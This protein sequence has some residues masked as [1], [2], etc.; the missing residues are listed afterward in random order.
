MMNHLRNL[1]FAVL[2]AAGLGTIA[3]LLI[4]NPYTHQAVALAI[5]S[6]AKKFTYVEVKFQAIKVSLLPLGID[7]FGLELVHSEK[8]EQPVI[9]SS[10][11]RA[12]ISLWALLLGRLRLSIIESRDL[13]FTW[14]L[15]AMPEHHAN[16]HLYGGFYGLLRDPPPLSAEEDHL[17][18]PLPFA[19]PIDRVML[20]SAKI[21]IDHNFSP[22][23]KDN[24][25]L[26]SANFSGLDLD[27][28]PGEF[29]NIA[30]KLHVGVAN[31]AIGAQSLIEDGELSL[32]GNITQ[33]AVHSTTF[34]IRSERANLAGSLTGLIQSTSNKP[35]LLESIDLDIKSKGTANLS[36]LGSILDIGDT[37]GLVTGEMGGRIFIPVESKRPLAIEVKGPAAVEDGYI[38]GIRLHNSRGDLRITEDRLAFDRVEAV[39]GKH[40]VGEAKGE[41]LFNDAIDFNFQI[42]PESLRLTEI[43]NVFNVDFDGVDFKMR[44]PLVNLKGKGFPFALTVDGALEL[45]ELNVALLNATPPKPSA[46]PSCFV[47]TQLRANIQSFFID[48]LEG[49]CL[50]K[51]S[52]TE[53]SSSTSPYEM[54]KPR[55]EKEASPLNV[56]GPIAFSEKQGINLKILS[57]GFHADLLNSM[58]PIELEGQGPITVVVHGPYNAVRADISASVNNLRAH[59]MPFGTV[60]GTATAFDD[61]VEWQNVTSTLPNQG[62]LWS[63]KGKLDFKNTFPVD[64]DFHA[65]NVSPTIVGEHIRSLFP[66]STVAFG[67]SRFDGQIRGR[68]LEPLTYIGEFQTALT[69]LSY[70]NETFADQLQIKGNASRDAVDISNIVARLGSLS[71]NASLKVDKSDEAVAAGK[72]GLWQELG[73]NLKDQVEINFQTGPVAT[74]TSPSESD[75]LKR[76][77]YIGSAL[78]TAGIGGQLTTKGSLKGPASQLVGTVEGSVAP[79]SILSTELAPVKFRT[80]VVGQKIDVVANH[81]GSSLE[82]RISMRLFEPGVPFEWYMR[83]NRLDLRAFGTPVF[84]KDPRNYAYFSGDWDLK[85]KISDFWRAEGKIQLSDLR[86]QFMRDVGGQ[87]KTAVLRNEKNA[88]VKIHDGFW[89]FAD[90]SPWTIGGDSLK[91]AVTLNGNRLPDNLNIEF[92][93]IVDMNLIREFVEQ[94]ESGTGKIKVNG[95]IKGTTSEPK[96]QLVLSDVEKSNT[97][98]WEPLS[99]GLADARPAFRNIR[100]KVIYENGHFTIDRLYAD[101]GNGHVTLNGT[102]Q[103][104]TE[105][106]E[107][108]RMEVSLR[109]AAFALPLSVFLFDSTVTGDLILSGTARPYKLSGQVQVTRARSGRDFDIRQEILNAALRSKSASSSNL[110]EPFMDL[111]VAVSARSSI[112]VT[113]R[114]LQGVLSADL[115]VT[116]NDTNPS[117]SG[118]VEVVRG[119]FFYRRDFTI[120]KGVFVFDDPLKPDPYLDVFAASEVGNYRVYITASGRASDPRIDLSVDPAVR[121]DGTP[122]S[123]VD[124]LLLLS[125]GSFPPTNRNGQ[126]GFSTEDASKSAGT[127]AL[128]L[129]VGQFEEPVEKLFDLSGQRIVRQVYIDTYLSDVSNKPMPR[130]NVP[131]NLSRDLDV[132]LRYDAE[133]TWRVSSEL[134]LH[135]SI[136]LFGSVEQQKDELRKQSK[137]P[138]DTGVDLRFRF[139]FP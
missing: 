102:I 35:S 34:S 136:S 94:V 82:A 108:S 36:I 133:G 18:W 20:Q 15:P 55:N 37:R 139:S 87:L 88:V 44:A 46:L 63:K 112:S 70:D 83:A 58:Q 125:S 42:K 41:I 77:P 114:N 101:K 9:K 126:G 16:S 98:N 107:E 19:L 14:P 106:N 31:L 118:Q 124:I 86:V 103:G 22:D 137:A 33:N 11:L 92:S 48:K 76:I 1:L 17:E 50:P 59:G 127:E 104:L 39:I 111:D 3:N 10:H 25:S 69:G 52:V 53:R 40:V 72:T 115:Q 116:G 29:R 71:A 132:M 134:P 56:S 60:N 43:L 67:I 96:I 73:G 4:D 13:E 7:L 12:K 135:D 28:K 2:L 75:H 30:A 78:A 131:L 95:S 121:D 54:S 85:G 89:Q 97:P 84:T 130:F 23:G 38:D 8:P 105:S 49:H 5:N 128:N 80:F 123:K 65:E 117:V 57:E 90:P 100:G 64:S 62:S 113:N 68:F 61:R 66:G 81:S 91:I 119:K 32:D 109:D 26:L 47:K 79:L 129:F 74:R 24:D 99:I 138:A 122:I 110:S 93:S 45:Y 120:R 27:F 21:A 51:V 6:K